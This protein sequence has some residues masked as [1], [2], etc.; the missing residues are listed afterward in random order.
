MAKLDPGEFE[1]AYARKLAQIE[2]KK[3]AL[4]QEYERKR[5]IE[6]DEFTYKPTIKHR[7]NLSKT[8]EKEVDNSFG[9]TGT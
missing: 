7:K 8:I 2:E 9:M 5:K 4:K 3:R 1:L 6:E